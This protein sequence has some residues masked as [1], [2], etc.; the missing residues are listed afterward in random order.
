MSVSDD[1]RSLLYEI[2][3]LLVAGGLLLAFMNG[4]EN[5]SAQAAAL[6]MVHRVVVPQ[7]PELVDDAVVPLVRD[8]FAR[9]FV[10]ARAGHDPQMTLPANAGALWMPMGGSTERTGL[11]LIAL[12]IG[13]HSS[14][15]LDDSG[16]LVTVSEGDVIHGHRVV[17]MTQTGIMWNDGSVLRVDDGGAL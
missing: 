4:A 3:W 7:L 8:P 6:T 15:L 5:F 10:S 11:R 12:S 13:P 16:S 14:A 1:L 2:G 17:R 9:V